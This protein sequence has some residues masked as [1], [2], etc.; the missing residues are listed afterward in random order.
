MK[1]SDKTKLSKPNGNAYNLFFPFRKIS[2]ILDHYVHWEGQ[3]WDSQWLRNCVC[4]DNKLFFS[5]ALKR[6]ESYKAFLSLEQVV[7]Q[8]SLSSKG[9]KL[10][11]YTVI[12]KKKFIEK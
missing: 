9:Y 5:T 10:D 2:V 4:W 11:L 3:V 12:V 1:A 8:I 7:F 6:W